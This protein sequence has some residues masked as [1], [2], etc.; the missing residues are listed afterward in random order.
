MQDLTVYRTPG[1]SVVVIPDD[2]WAE[3][4]EAR[5]EIDGTVYRLVIRGTNTTDAETETFAPVEEEEPVF[6]Y[7]PAADAGIGL[8][9]DATTPEDYERTTKALLVETPKEDPDGVRE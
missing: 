8:L 4:A 9:A 5:I 1:A 3:G 2:A 6:T 7:N